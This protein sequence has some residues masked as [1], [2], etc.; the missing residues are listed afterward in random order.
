M[1]EGE[2]ELKAGVF[3]KSFLGFWSLMYV[4]AKIT[5]GAALCNHCGD[6]EAT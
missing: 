2:A 4:N 5:R 3:V 6:N 1:F